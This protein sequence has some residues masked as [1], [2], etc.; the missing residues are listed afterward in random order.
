MKTIYAHSLYPK[1]TAQLFKPY[2][3]GYKAYSNYM[4]N[5]IEKQI[6]DKENVIV[7]VLD[8]KSFYS[9]ISQKKIEDVFKIIEENL[10]LEQFECYVNEREKETIKESSKKLKDGGL[11]IGIESSRIIGNVVGLEIDNVILKSRPIA[12]TRYVDDIMVMFKIIEDD[13]DKSL[14]EPENYILGLKDNKIAGFEINIGK[15]KTILINGEQ[16]DM[17]GIY[18]NLLDATPSFSE[19]IFEIQEENI[20]AIYDLQFGNVK[21]ENFVGIQ[22]NLKKIKQ[23]LSVSY[24]QIINSKFYNVPYKKKAKQLEDDLIML[25]KNIDDITF[26]N[27]SDYWVKMYELDTLYDINIFNVEQRIEQLKFKLKNEDIIK[28]KNFVDYSNEQLNLIKELNKE[29]GFKQANKNKNTLTSKLYKLEVSNIFELQ[30]DKLN[31]IISNKENK[32]KENK[33]KEN[34]KTDELEKK[35]NLIENVDE[36][37][38]RKIH[39]HLE[40]KL[41]LLN[42]YVLGGVKVDKSKYSKNYDMTKV[43]KVEN[44][45]DFTIALHVEKGNEAYIEDFLLYNISDQFKAEK[46]KIKAK[47]LNNISRYNAEHPKKLDMIVLPEHNILIDDLYDYCRFAKKNKVIVS[48]GL[49]HLKIGNNV[50]NLIVDIIPVEFKEVDE[51]G[52]IKYKYND[53]YIIFRN[54]NFPSIQEKCIIEETTDDNGI[55][56]QVESRNDKFY[57]HIKLHEYIQFVSYNCYEIYD[58]YSRAEVSSKDSLILIHEN[59]KDVETFGNITYSWSIDTKAFLAQVNY[60]EYG[61]ILLIQPKS[62]NYKELIKIKGA[63]NELFPV[64]S[65]DFESLYRSRRSHTHTKKNNYKPT[66]P[67]L[68]SYPYKEK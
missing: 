44:I 63:N 37:K 8:I 23:I 7:F 40:Q 45:K 57:N 32:N 31:E 65:M 19:E 4:I 29:I 28:Y 58:I 27:L 22:P 62:R 16:Q 5:E 54:K 12:Y 9:S 13:N 42:E 56:Y 6:Q 24:H 30:I 33:N 21:L 14:L 36:D 20:E 39:R 26:I 66:P 46:A 10:E 17:L 35:I 34:I 38:G 43:Y 67:N 53:A 1:N 3:I 51:F 48:G 61:D 2:I 25:E 15:T 47:M 55:Y 41:E 59:N 11:P 64:S 68:Q 60:S 49:Q 50:Y 18:R 52:M